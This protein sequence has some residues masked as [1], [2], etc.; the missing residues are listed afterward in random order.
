VKVLFT[1]GYTNEMFQHRTSEPLANF[2]AKPYRR[3]ELATK[4][5]A[6]LDS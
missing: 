3:R 6:V 2:L 1:S 4:L 5:R